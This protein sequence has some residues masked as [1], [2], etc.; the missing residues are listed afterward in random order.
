MEEMHYYPF[1]LTMAGISSNALKSTNYPENRFK[2]N[3]K[4][5]QNREFQD[6]SGLDWY[7][8]GARLL[9]PQIGRWESIDP[10]A[11]KFYQWSPY[12]SMADNPIRYI[13][14]NGK[15]FLN[16]DANGNYT[17]TTKDNWWHNFWHG[18]KGRILDG[19]G[20]VTQKF[21]FADPKNDVKDIQS[22]IIKRVQFVKE[23]DIKNLM[24]NAG[25][26][27]PENKVENSNKRYEYILAQ[28]KGGGKFDFSYSGIPNQFPGASRSP[29]T[30][31][32][33]MIFLIDGV[34]HNI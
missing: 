20:K 33:S 27:D 30:K 10:L 15:K 1:R 4:E 24:A 3:G 34:A 5:F 28:G 2:Y 13:D 9:D 29:V 22:G 6:A 7:N 25:V 32:S 18:S 19:K 8:F 16:L 17:N 26:F 11:S 14:P 12:V 23:D 21:S 31:P